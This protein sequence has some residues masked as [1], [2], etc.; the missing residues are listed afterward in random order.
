MK[1]IIIHF[2]FFIFIFFSVNAQ[3]KDSTI[4]MRDVLKD[5]PLITTPVFNNVTKNNYYFIINAN[6]EYAPLGIGFVSEKI[7]SGKGYF[8][9]IKLSEDWITRNTSRTP[10]LTQ[11]LVS[12]F[13]KPA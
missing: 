8:I 12:Q 5:G 10:D 2:L 1:K 9:Q 4:I 7:N 3:D 6:I 13:Y 11:E